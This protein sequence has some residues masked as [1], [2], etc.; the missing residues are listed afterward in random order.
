[1]N[2]RRVPGGRREAR[3]RAIKGEPRGDSEAKDLGDVDKVKTK[4][5]GNKKPKKQAAGEKVQDT[6]S[7]LSHIKA[8][9]S[10]IAQKN[11]Q[12]QRNQLA[13]GAF[14]GIRIATHILIIIVIIIDNNSGLLRVGLLIRLLIRLLV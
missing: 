7:D 11:G 8:M 6:G 4:I 2:R 13:F 3:R 9:N 12:H 14:I 10:P 5:S 1:M